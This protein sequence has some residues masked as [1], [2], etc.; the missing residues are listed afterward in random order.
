MKSKTVRYL[1]AD[2]QLEKTCASQCSDEQ[3]CPSRLAS[4]SVKI[5]SLGR[6]ALLAKHIESLMLKN[7]FEGPK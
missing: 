2:I 1:E 5:E 3:D 7:G 6:S 4:R